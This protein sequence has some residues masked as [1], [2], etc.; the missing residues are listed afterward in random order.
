MYRKGA[1]GRHV[2]TG[3][4]PMTAT[5]VLGIDVSKE[6]LVCALLDVPTRKPRW[7][8]SFPNTEAG[9]R[10]LLEQTPP[11]ASWVMEPTGNYSLAVAKRAQAAGR[12]VLMADPKAA[13]HY[14]KSRQG[15]AK[16]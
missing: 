15:R 11:D 3:R 5:T 8:K 7:Q 13:H 6:T 12:T 4:S 16:T 9:A 2:A 1:W 10:K 14:L